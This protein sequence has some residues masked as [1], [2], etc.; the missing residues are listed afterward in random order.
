MGKVYYDMGFLSTSEVVECSASDFIGQFVGQTGPKTKAKLDEALGKVLF[1]D[2]AYRLATGQYATEAVQELVYLLST[3][4][5]DSKIVVILAGY[6][7]DMNKLMV[8][9]PA[10]SG[11]FP[12]EIIFHNISAADCLTLL[13]RELALKRTS[14]PFLKDTSNN[15]YIQLLRMIKVLSHIPSWSN[16]RDIKTL[17]KDMSWSATRGGSV[18]SGRQRDLSANQ[19]FQCTKKMLAMQLERYKEQEGYGGKPALTSLESAR[20]VN[21]QFEDESSYTVM[22]ETYACGASSNHEHQSAPQ[23]SKGASCALIRTGAPS[24]TPL[25]PRRDRQQGDVGTTREDSV[26]DVVWEQLQADKEI[27]ESRLAKASQ[28]ARRKHRAV[29]EKIRQMG[30]CPQGFEWIEQ[31]CGYVCAGGSHY[32]SH[33]QLG[34]F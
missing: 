16:A 8:A 18:A 20:A 9:R 11:L 3:P 22:E 26:S 15:G 25:P 34:D 21:Q 5:Y 1:V 12:D 13:D 6:T 14:A 27:Q 4:R 7:Q 17:A 32:V 30:L 31:S 2:E 23:L 33:E 28:T 24:Q 29:Q 10:L 19:A